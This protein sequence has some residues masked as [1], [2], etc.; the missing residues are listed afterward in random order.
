VP[1]PPPPPRS[2]SPPESQPLLAS[3]HHPSHGSSAGHGKGVLRVPAAA[4]DE[5]RV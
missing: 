2:K 1:K 4:M 5:M 3:H